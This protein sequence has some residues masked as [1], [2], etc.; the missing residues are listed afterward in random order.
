MRDL[1]PN[2]DPETGE[3]RLVWEAN[4]ESQQDQFKITYHELETLNGDSSS[5][6]VDETMFS[7]KDNLQPVRNYSCE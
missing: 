5:L 2:T 7:T 4:L 3:I 6:Q 1:W